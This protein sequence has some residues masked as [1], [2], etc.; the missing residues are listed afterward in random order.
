M[1][2]HVGLIIFT[3]GLPTSDDLDACLPSSMPAIN[4]KAL[5]VILLIQVRYRK[6]PHMQN[7]MRK[8]K[9]TLTLTLTDTGG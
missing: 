3:R 5:R 2:F 6:D 1:K 4:L 8:L 9:L 7:S